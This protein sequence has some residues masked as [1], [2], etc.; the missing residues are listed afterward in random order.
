[1]RGSSFGYLIKEGFRN[2]R[3]NRAIS[4][5]AIGVLVA[6][7]LLVGASLLFSM[8]INSLVGYFESQN[9]IVI[10]LDDS[11]SG[12][13]LTKLDDELRAVGNI[14][15]A[16]FVSREEGLETWM[17][18][19]GDD[20]TLLE[21]LVEDNPL[22]NSYRVVIT[23][24]SK[25]DETVDEIKAIRGVESVSASSEVAHA[26]T[27]LKQAVSLSSLAVIGILAAVSLCI[28][29]NTIRITVFNRRKEIS[30]MKYPPALSLG[31]GAPR[32]PVCNHR[33]LPA[34]G[35]VR[36]AALLAERQRP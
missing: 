24:L 21:W 3:Q 11:V 29:A 34:L 20:G 17:K 15:S 32:L 22:Q 4:V 9:E 23:D 1:M 5:A 25:M 14:S 31:R 30:I 26:V 36:S 6:C 10:F 28:V 18:E 16:T 12:S 33:F 13:R 8:N 19:L 35:R 7:L 27:G 2:L